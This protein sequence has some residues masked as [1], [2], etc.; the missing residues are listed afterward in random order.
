MDKNFGRIFGAGLV[1]VLVIIALVFFFKRGDHL[2]PHGSVLK[3]RSIAL[4]D[5][6]ALLLLDIRLVNDSDVTMTVSAISMSVDLADG[7]SVTGHVLGK[8][9]LMGT[10]GY[11][12]LLGEKYNPALAT[13]DEIPVRSKADRMISASFEVPLAQLESRKKVTVKIEDASGAVAEFTGK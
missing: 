4:N 1:V 3:E 5:D 9:D 8:S 13:R 6:T 7:G 11:F 12:P 10:F 2:D